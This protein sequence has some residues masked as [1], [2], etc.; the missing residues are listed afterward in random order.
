MFS[1]EYASPCGNWDNLFQIIILTLKF[2]DVLFFKS[3]MPV[4]GDV[5][6]DKSEITHQ[7]PQF[8][9]DTFNV[10]PRFLLQ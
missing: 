5:K 1:E 9:L 8:Y 10:L 4:I 7:P 6:G 2:V 3:N